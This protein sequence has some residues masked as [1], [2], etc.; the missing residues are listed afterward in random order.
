MERLQLDADRPKLHLHVHRIHLD[1][2][3]GGELGPMRRLDDQGEVGGPLRK[4]QVEELVGATDDAVVPIPDM[5][6]AAV[7]AQV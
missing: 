7:V 2:L 6:D 4:L 1:R 3:R 5:D